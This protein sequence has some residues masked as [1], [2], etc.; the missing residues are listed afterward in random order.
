MKTYIECIPCIMNQTI[1]TLDLCDCTDKI[2]KKVMG[3][4]IQNL[5]NI[6]YEL[7]P[8]ENTDV[9]YELISKYTGVTDPYGNIK[10]EH[11]IKALKLYPELNEILNLDKDKLHMAARIAIA[12]NIIDMGISYN[13]SDQMNY[14]RIIKNITD[15]P[16]AIDDSPDFVKNL[17]I[18]KNIL[19]LADNAG[20]IVFDKF[21][22]NELV[23]K[24]KNVTVSVKSGP[25][26][27]DA[28]LEDAV[29]VGIDK[30]ANI[31]RTGHNKIGNC[32]KY[33]SDEF[34]KVFKDA[35]LII[36][37]GQ[38]NFETLDKEKAPIYFLLKAK[39]KC[40][41]RELNV[42]YLDVVF[43]KSRS[44]K[45]FRSPGLSVPCPDFHPDDT[46]Q[47]HLF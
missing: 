16:L 47:N 46:M 37:K 39:C 43:V 29:E 21:F 14:H 2:K 44:F 45:S 7:S 40:V 11:N 23:K 6:D 8:S 4:L 34:L 13:H 5:E 9:A 33:T 28:N 18:S 35:D 32:L 26:I 22:I 30:I 42:N 19:Y 36:S 41:A 20:E 1:A 12:G 3:E 31:I 15:V 27:N 10:K 17:D 24:G 38:G 25:I